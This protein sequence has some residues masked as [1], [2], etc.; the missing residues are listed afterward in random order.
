VKKTLSLLGVQCHRSG[1]ITGL[2]AGM[3]MMVARKHCAH[4][5]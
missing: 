3:N 5:S 2:A 1:Y 4:S